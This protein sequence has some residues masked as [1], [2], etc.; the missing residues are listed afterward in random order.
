MSIASALTSLGATFQLL[1]GAVA[2]R[3]DAKITEATKELNRQII[4]VQ[5]A[6]LQLQEK[7]S[8]AV[9]AIEALKDER[10]ELRER[11]AEL[12]RQ[13]R[14]RDAYKLVQL[15]PGSFAYAPAEI[16]EPPA[17]GYRL[18][19]PCMDNRAKKS[20][21]QSMASD[22]TQVYCPECKAQFKIAER[23]Y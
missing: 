10:R 5:N 1:Q 16:D 13:A 21:L 11:I 17:E 14:E 12:D 23:E 3:D 15:L 6:C 8:A 9:E 2:I 18:C 7:Q 4:E 20:V 19:Q 22:Y